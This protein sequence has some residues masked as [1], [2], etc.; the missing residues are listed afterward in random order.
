MKAFI[1]NIR[2]VKSQ[3]VFQ[4]VQILHNFHKFSFMALMEPF[5]HVRTIN[6]YRTR[7]KI[8]HVTYN[9]K[10][11][12]WVFTNHVYNT[13]VTSKNYAYNTIIIRNSKKKI[14]I[15]MKD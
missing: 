7:L 3:K 9:I 4:R 8:L 15:N 5:Q 6:G 12:I 14:T 11:N 2:S 10:G 13:I 1:W